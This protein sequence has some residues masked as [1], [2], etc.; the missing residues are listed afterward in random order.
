MPVRELGLRGSSNTRGQSAK[1]CKSA[2]PHR[3]HGVDQ[4]MP[5]A[6]ES[7]VELRLGE[8]RAGRLEDVIGSAQFLDLTLQ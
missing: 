7:A 4:C 5:S 1:P 6:L 3:H 8:K 2:R